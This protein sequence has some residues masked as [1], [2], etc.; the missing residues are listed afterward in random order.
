M[1]GGIRVRV[2]CSVVV[3]L[4][5]AAA[6][7][8]SPTSQALSTVHLTVGAQR[9]TAS[10]PTGVLSVTPA[11]MSSVPPAPTGSVLPVGVLNVSVT[12]VTPGSVVTVTITLP[13]K[14][15][16]FLK[17]EG[18]DWVPFP[19]VGSTGATLSS[20]GKTVT[21]RLQDG[22]RGDD[23][24]AANGVIEDPDGVALAG[25][26]ASQVSAGGAHG[27]A[28]VAGGAVNCWGYDQWGQAGDPGLNESSAPTVV[29][30]TTGA[31]EVAGGI[32]TS[33]ALMPAGAVQCWGDNENDQLGNG[34]TMDHSVT[35]TQ[36]TGISG[37]TQITM[38]GAQAC[39]LMGDETVECW[40]DDQSGQLGDGLTDYGSTVP[41]PVVGLT[42]VTQVAGYSQDTCALL[43][44]TTVK[45][46]G[47]NADGE[48]GNGTTTSSNVPVAVSGLGGVTMLSSGPNMNACAV[49]ISGGVDCWGFNEFGD[50]G[51]GTTV[52]ALTPVPVLG[53][54][55]AVAVT[56]GGDQSCA[57]LSDATVSCWGESLG[58]PASVPGLSD[59]TQVSAGND[60]DLALR[61]D[62]SVVAWGSDNWGQLGDGYPG[63]EGINTTY[64]A[65]PVEVPAPA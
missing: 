56:G 63:A 48:L 50:L 59:V 58:L 24:G 52:D 35:P 26:T 34:T 51:I 47:Q 32:T 19:V 20:S 42:D 18:G 14:V 21:L 31:T 64:T 22:G 53:I 46:W 60:D 16:S 12:D 55:A 28:L 17:L 54:T 2:G 8:C 36:V 1:A 25:L 44:D 9:V 7:G 33:C 29:A 23:D 43:A 3:A 62:G 49:L 61:R 65:T 11:E 15:T 13:R 5:V 10:S 6:A 41:Q 45:C 27:C 4:A 40:G 30:G 38:G 57:L 37:A 39:A